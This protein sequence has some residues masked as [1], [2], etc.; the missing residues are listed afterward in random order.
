MNVYLFPHVTCCLTCRHF[1]I[2]QNGVIQ[3]SM[4]AI[5]HMKHS[6]AG[7]GGIIINVSSLAGTNYRLTK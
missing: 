4:L 3:G 6:N 2:F 7:K 5:D 1:L